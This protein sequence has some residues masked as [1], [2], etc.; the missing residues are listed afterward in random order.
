M[1]SSVI[2]RFY[3]MTHNVYVM[4]SA[5]IHA[6]SAKSTEL[7]RQFEIRLKAHSLNSYLWRLARSNFRTMEGGTLET[8]SQSQVENL[9]SKIEGYGVRAEP[10]TS[11]GSP[12]FFLTSSELYNSY[13][14]L[15]NSSGNCPFYI[16]M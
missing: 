7:L 14:E 15:C 16:C 1:G 5:L 4:V 2:L 10:Q 9:W 3:E 8:L 6:N 13:L 12:F 11:D